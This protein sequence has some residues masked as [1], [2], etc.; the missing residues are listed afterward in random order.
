[1]EFFAEY[2]V[3][4]A[5]TVTLVIAILVVLASFA[6]LRSKGRRKS[7]GQL[8]VSKLNDFY[9]GLRERLEQTLLDKDQLKAL[10]K[11]QSKSEKKQ[12]KTPE[13]KQ[14]V[15]VLD[16]D[17]DL[18]ASATASLR[19]EISALLQVARAGDEALLRL[20]SAGGVVHGYGLAAS[21]LRRI[22]DK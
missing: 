1:M 10:R 13:T 18:Q 9:K 19:E 3:F 14:R 8:Q 4:L 17:G 5:K 7:T 2:A 12:K 16:F 21:Q 15:F 20:E 22:R 6:A 11:S